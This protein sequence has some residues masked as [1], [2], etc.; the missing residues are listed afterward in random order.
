MT[1]KSQTKHL[2]SRVDLSLYRI[3]LISDNL[4]PSLKTTIHSLNILLILFRNASTDTSF[5]KIKVREFN[6]PPPPQRIRLKTPFSL[7]IL[8]LQLGQ[9]PLVCW[10]GNMPGMGVRDAGVPHHPTVEL[11]SAHTVRSPYKGDGLSHCA[12]FPI[13]RTTTFTWGKHAVITGG[14]DSWNWMP[15]QTDTHTHT[16]TRF[17]LIL[18]KSVPTPFSQINVQQ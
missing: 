13:S 3:N 1:S 18:L 10:K 4:N 9:N 16:H 12:Q 5:G 15:A 11:E 14:K 8:P 6:T 17:L 7:H 2:P